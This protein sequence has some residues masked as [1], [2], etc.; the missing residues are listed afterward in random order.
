MTFLG[1]VSVIFAFSILVLIHELGHFLAARWMG[2]R[3]EKFSIGFPPT[4][5]SKKIGDTEFSISAIP[6]GGYVKMAGFID[7]NM[8]SEI[9][10]ADDEYSSKPVWKRIIIISAGV[11][12]NLLLAIALYTFISYSQG[13][14]LNPV[15]TIKV[16]GETGVAQKIGFEDGDKI[17]KINDDEIY[18]WRELFFGFFNNIE[19][20]I[21]F[22]VLRDNQK[23]ILEYKQEWLKEENGELLNIGPIFPA[24]IGEVSS[25][26][27]AEIAGLQ[28][29]DLITEIN[30]NSVSNWDEMTGIIRDNA[31]K[32]INIKWTRENQLFESSITPKL[33]NATDEK[34]MDVSFG[35]IGVY[36]HYIQKP[37]SF[38]AA[39]KR[40]GVQPFEM[41]YMNII[42]L[43]WLIT[44]VKSAQETIGGPG[45]IAKM[46]SDAADRGWVSY[47]SFI[48][49]LSS[50]LAFF[51]TLPIPALDGGH[52]TFLLVEGVMG[53][54]L[55]IKTR[56]VI[57][58]IG[59]ALLLSLIVFVLYVD[60]NRLF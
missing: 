34:G 4:L 23:I 49:L 28:F 52:L 3:V 60:F 47:V 36:R 19:S 24:R 18:H 53:R 17:L 59:M 21:E 45:T 2:V 8:D 29:N 10:G 7:E 22:E 37:I 15:T 39:L 58:Q 46:L 13:E 38:F 50:V 12:M 27:P 5:F 11:I 6:L 44:G 56:L 14:V 57:Q 55:S 33:V 51:N 30:G 31:E 32:T 40:G 16:D 25:G 41:I 26:D 9:S 54:P 20:D 43:K 48:A 1:I 42:G 35:R